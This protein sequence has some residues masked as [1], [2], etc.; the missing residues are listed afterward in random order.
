MND[1]SVHSSLL[2]RV[3][4]D[5]PDGWRQLVHIC[6]PLVQ[7]WTRRTGLNE[8]DAADVSQE[9]LRSVHQNIQNFRRDAPAD[10]FRGWLWTI[11]QNKTLDFHRRRMRNPIAAGGTAACE[12]F[13]ELPAA[14][15]DAELY[16]ETLGMVR[17]ALAILQGDFQPQTWQAFWRTAIDGVSADEAAAELKMSRGAVYVARSRCLVR[18]REELAGL[19]NL[20]RVISKSDLPVS[21]E[22]Q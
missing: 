3:R 18:L 9:V 12:Q 1:S 16:D 7:R 19:V 10:S 11:T 5:D 2:M 15:E 4:A 6:G 21:K 14:P 13:Q 20:D 22:G 17:R 8:A